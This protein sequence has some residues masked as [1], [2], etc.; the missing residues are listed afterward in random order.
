ML[1][2]LLDELGPRE[3][4]TDQEAAAARY[5]QTKLQEFGYDTD[6]QEVIVED[7]SLVGMGLTL[8]TAEP[9]EFKAL[10]L[11]QS[12]LGVV[13]GIL[14]RVGLAMRGDIPED[15]LEGRIA[16]A[17]RGVI[18]FQ[19]K[20]ENVFATGAVG[21]VIYNNVLGLFRGVLATQPDFPVISMSRSDGEAIEDLLSESE[22]EA[23]IALTLEDLA[24]RNVVA[25]KIGPGEAV[26]VLGGHYDTVPE[27]AGANASGIAVLLTIARM[28]EDIDLPFTLR[29]VPFGSEELGLL[30]S[31]FY[32]E[33]LSEE[34]LATYAP[35]LSGIIGFVEQLGEV[36]TENVEPLA[37]VVDITLRLRED[38]ITDGQIQEKI[39][40]NA[41]E[42]LEGFFVVPKVVE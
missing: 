4:A 35:Q 2:E 20:A 29:I 18:T 32:V 13:T 34:E 12:G 23:S 17:K 33:S 7:L 26:V 40:A 5:L 6:I 27:V 16:F 3:S 14:T 31:R 9:E 41:P 37:N 38:E 1:G 24:S 19:A 28:L 30:G 39:L 8:N 22:V 10:P 25:E 11:D 36:D 15:G 42:T 21:L